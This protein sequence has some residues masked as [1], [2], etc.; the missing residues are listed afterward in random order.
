[1]IRLLCLA[2]VLAPP[3]SGSDTIAITNVRIIR[4]SKPEIASGTILIKDG[5]IAAVGTDVKVPEG[6]R[7]VDGKGR[8]ALPGMVHPSS[9]IGAGRSVARGSGVTPQV[10]AVDELNPALDV[11]APLVRCGFTAY[12][13]APAGGPIAGQGAV[14]KPVEGSK[15]RKILERTA[16]LKI[17]MRANTSTKDALRK[18]L[19]GAKKAIEAEKKAAAAKKKPAAEKKPAP[20]AT[21]AKP[22]PAPSRPTTRKPDEK[23]RILMGFLKGEIPAIVT[24]SSASDLLHYWQVM[25]G[26]SGFKPKVAFE[27][28]SD[29]YK[30]AALLG[31]RKARVVLRPGLTYVPMTRDRVNPAAEVARAGAVVAFAP[32]N[33]GSA[34]LEG[35]R[36][37]IAELVKY[38]LGRDVAIRA[39][40]LTPAE[41]L[42]VAERVGS[43]EAGK[44]ADLVLFDG[45]P[46]DPS[47]R[48]RTVL[49]N[50]ETVYSEE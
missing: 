32:N 3:D 14:V 20:G 25:E 5:K 43:I 4:V 34:A 30:A 41:I 16:F 21:P 31:K 48:I 6:A 7:V 38:G 50:G 47:S 11:Y 1:M 28:P 2:L 46:F 45:D 15:A 29:V 22:A 49:V 33:D 23:T 37:R 39:V 12:G 27:A 9:R 44:D 42:G 10:V 26:F 40:T 18:A 36:F 13:F 8:V 17:N 19:D 24:V 35:Y